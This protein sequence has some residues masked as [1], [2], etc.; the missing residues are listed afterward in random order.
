MLDDALAA[1]GRERTALGIS[2]ERL[3]HV[4][5][6][7]EVVGHLPASVDEGGPEGELERRQRGVVVAPTALAY[8]KSLHGLSIID[9]K[10]GFLNVR[11]SLLHEAE[12]GG[13]R[14]VRR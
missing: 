3:D 8:A 6:E 2:P 4:P 10:C 14:L 7:V 9:P 12:L 1:E 13:E 11:P 5:R